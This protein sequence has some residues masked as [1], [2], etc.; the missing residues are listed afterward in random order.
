[1]MPPRFTHLIELLEHRALKQPDSIALGFLDDGVLPGS[2]LTYAQ[3]ANQSANL[4]RRLQS[5]AEPGV[6]ALLLLPAGLDFV[7][8]FFACLRA[9]VIAVPV[10]AP[11]P[12]RLSRTIG[13][14]QAIAA[15]AE[16]SVI[17]SDESLRLAGNDF[18]KQYPALCSA[19]WIEVNGSDQDE[20]FSPASFAKCDTALLQYTS[21]STAHPRGVM[22]THENLL[23][24][25]EAIEKRV[26]NHEG[27]VSVSWLPP[28]HDMGLVGGIL[29]PIYGG[30]PGWLMSPATF[31]QRPVRWLE[32]ISSLRATFSGGPDFAYDLCVRRIAPEQRAALEL[33]SWNYAFNGAEPVRE[34]TMIEFSRAF[35]G[36]GF[37]RSAWRPV[38]GLAEATLMVSGGDPGSKYHSRELA[39]EALENHRVEDCVGDGRG[40]TVVGCGP[41]VK[42]TEVLVV[43]PETRAVCPIGEV[44]ELW[45]RG[46]GVALGYWGK[47]DPVFEGRLLDSEDRSYLRTGDLGFLADGEIY[48]TGRLKDLIIIRGRKLYPQDIEL[49]VETSHPMIR[50][51]ACAAFSILD[52]GV[53]SVAVAVEIERVTSDDYDALRE[54]V[55]CAI[56]QAV[57]E[58]HEVGLAQVTLLRPGSLPRTTSGKIRRSALQSGMP[59]SQKPVSMSDAL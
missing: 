25:L 34:K 8:A 1:M 18:Y 50:P 24:N 10:P 53:E 15:D 47:T 44:G 29:Q 4:S 48:V 14:L 7:V 52:E 55:I 33:S 40:V 16:A 39:A 56:R 59:H 21:G 58:T 32:A 12:A 9:G 5:C 38:Y 41:P 26:G 51:H 43:H 35:E 19:R 17:I 20:A 23:G 45:V 31:L 30:Y 22:V 57:S 11:H 3:L 6:R 28:F 13:R 49:T 54:K 2:R 36:S 42:N 37:P 27:S 46:P